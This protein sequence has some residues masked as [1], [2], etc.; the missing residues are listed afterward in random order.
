MISFIVGSAWLEA[1][2]ADSNQNWI[3]FFDQN[4]NM[5][6]P[7]KLPQLRDLGEEFTCW[8][9]VDAGV[10]N[11]LKHNK[12]CPLVSGYWKQC[13]GKDMKPLQ[14]KKKRKLSSSSPS[15]D[16]QDEAAAEAGAVAKEFAEAVDAA[17]DE[18]VA[19]GKKENE[20]K[21]SAADE[22]LDRDAAEIA[23]EVARVEAE[24]KA[25][26]EKFGSLVPCLE[27]FRVYGPWYYSWLDSKYSSMTC[28]QIL[29][30]YGDNSCTSAK[31]KNH[32]INVCCPKMCNTKKELGCDEDKI[33]LGADE[34]EKGEKE[35]NIDETADEPK[36]PGETNVA[37][38]M[39]FAALSAIL[40]LA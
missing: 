13:E 14:K 12:Y 16:P 19:D 5:D 24:W 28:K 36:Q 9:L 2:T 35:A 1:V 31:S 32:G 7:S 21:S 37:S 17:Q 23:K 10:G 38:A 15:S 4:Q 25:N 3:P 39:G 22:D 30:T 40:V 26:E 18:V 29:A 11:N 8:D 27:K 33:D 34:E 20:E 6:D